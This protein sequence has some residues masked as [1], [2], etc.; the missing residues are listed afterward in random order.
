MPF[1]IGFALVS[2][3]RTEQHPALGSSNL[4]HI[5]ASIHTANVDMHTIWRWSLEHQTTR[6]NTVCNCPHTEAHLVL[7][8]ASENCM[9]TSSPW[10]VHASNH[11][12]QYSHSLTH[13]SFVNAT[14]LQLWDAI[15][16][17]STAVSRTIL[18]YCTRV[19]YGLLNLYSI[20]SN[21]YEVILNVL[22]CV[23]HTRLATVNRIVI[24]V[25]AC[26]YVCRYI[27]AA[28]VEHVLTGLSEFACTMHNT[29]WRLMDNRV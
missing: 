5:L 21:D 24:S 4:D 13:A 7:Q 11:T 9:G 16:I 8:H 29:G 6:N 27:S 14:F 15:I 23:H 25:H 19:R 2:Y 26:M 10:P 3:V 28:Y 20:H 1:F 22:T 12:T 18:S 17:H